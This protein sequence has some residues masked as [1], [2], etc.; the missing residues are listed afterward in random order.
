MQKRNP[1]SAS[2]RLAALPLALAGLFNVAHAQQAPAAAPAM[3]A[4][5]K[6]SAKKVYFER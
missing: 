1:I 3:T 5:E 4:E 6:A 2:L